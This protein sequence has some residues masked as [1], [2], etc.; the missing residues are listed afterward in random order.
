[1]VKP[2]KAISKSAIWFKLSVL[3]LLLIALIY[4]SGLSDNL[5]IETDWSDRFIFLSLLSFCLG[6]SLRNPY[7]KSALLSAFALFAAV[8]LG[9]IYLGLNQTDTE[10]QTRKST[11]KVGAPEFYDEVYHSLE[12][13]SIV[14]VNAYNQSED[15]QDAQ[16]EG[17]IVADLELA[18]VFFLS[19]GF[20]IADKVSTPAYA[21]EPDPKLGYRVKKGLEQQLA[22]KQ[23]NNKTIFQAI[24]SY[25]SDGRRITPDHPGATEAVVFL[26]CSFTLGLGLND[27]DTY[28]YKVAEMLGENYQVFNFGES[29]YGT[30]QALALI[31]NGYLDEIARKYDKMHVF[32]MNIPSH[33][34]RNAGQ[35]SWDKDGPSYQMTLDGG[36]KHMG[37]FKEILGN[38]KEK[39]S[40]VFRRLNDNNFMKELHLAIIR[41]ADRT[42]RDQYKSKLVVLDVYPSEDYMKTL[43]KDNIPIL[44]ML[45]NADDAEFRIP[46]D[47]HPNEL[48]TTVYAKRV[49]DYLSRSGQPRKNSD[50]SI[51]LSVQNKI[52]ARETEN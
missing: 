42:L 12:P 51:A 46:G 19:R 29:G 20:A 50:Q 45:P 24:Y 43:S 48:A 3:V 23:H 49:V 32:Y 30:H 7:L 28:P 39:K 40:L 35:A 21:Y 1:M 2:N 52:K 41:Q 15:A 4:F 27:E 44:V 22:I 31:E 26:G 10:I 17:E 5:F 6:M 34:E 13:R 9:E 11:V 25:N 36:V 14:V 38:D 33:K 8:G 37:S 18:K 47:G 16:S